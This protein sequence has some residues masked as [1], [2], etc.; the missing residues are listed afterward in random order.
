METPPPRWPPGFRFSPTDEELVLYFLKRRIAAGRPTPYIADVDV[1]KSHPSHLPERSALRTGDKQWFFCSRLDRKYP[2]GSRASRTTAD[3]YW[4]ATGKDRSICNGGRAV[5]N[6]KTLVYHHGR[7]PRG[8]RTDWVM[9]E[10][11]ILPEAL[12]PAAHGRE[13]FALYKLFE[14]S[15][16]GPK[17]GEQYGAP[18][19]EEDWLD[20]DDDIGAELAVVVADPIPTTTVPRAATVDEQ[21]GDLEVL[22]LQSQDHQRNSEQ[23]SDF[24]TTPVSSQAPPHH[25]HRQ[26][27][28]PSDDDANTAEAADATTSSGAMLAAEN[29]ELP[30]GDLEGLLMEISDDQRTAR[31]FPEFS[32]QVSQLQL[33]DDDLQAWPNADMEEISVAD[34]A[35]S[36]GVADASECTGTELPFG[37]LEGLLLQLENDQENVELLADFSAPVPHHSF[38]QVGNGDFNGCE[39]DIVNSVD[40]SSAMQESTD[41]DP[42]SELSNQI[43]QSALTNMPLSWETNCAEETSAP[44]TVSGLA[45]YDCRDADEE[46]LEI[47]DFFDLEDVGQG[48][49]CTATEHLTSA[50]NG[51]HDSLEYSD[52]PM[53]LPGSFGTAG[54]GTENQNGY[55]GDSGS[56]NQGFEYT[57][58]SW[59][60]NQ[61]A[62]NVRNRMQY[63]HVVFSSHASGTANIHMMNGE[64]PNRSPQDSESWFNAAVSALLDAVPATPALAAENNVLNRT[65][66]RISSFR[67]EQAPNEEPS[68]PLAQ[69]RRRGTG[70][71]SVSLLVLLA[72]ILW[73]FATGTGYAIRFCKDLWRSST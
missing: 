9:H 22:L 13:A 59:T 38:H 40:P 1:Y 42:R 23:H 32:A 51:M 5:G 49:N 31:S 7:A 73:A 69:V 55:F 62:L 35:A 2:N 37:D 65:L 48:V 41:L 12:P 19:R 6:K 27:W 4:K 47:N 33:P 50:S 43:A 52:A 25:G 8:E 14:K 71:I 3:G 21:I 16:A 60:Q 34:Y 17:N 45:S 66:Q 29:T 68:A 24:S 20:D 58:E 64:L 10:Y 46:F 61:V 28:P 36:S 56:Q 44:R 70:L 26:S 57:S 67:S 53:F 18:F 30:L 54:V 72:A 39:G 63:N 15:G 11:T